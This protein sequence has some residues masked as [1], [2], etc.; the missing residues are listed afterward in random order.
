MELNW[1]AVILA[2][3]AGM[4]VAMAW[5]SKGPLADAWQRLTGILPEQSKQ[6]SR[7][8]LVQLVT[9]NALT[10]L[11][12]AVANGIA[13]AALGNDSVC[14]WLAL[15]VGLAAWLTLSASTMLQHTAFELKPPQL[16]L[17]NAAYQLAL[18]LSMA[19]VIGLV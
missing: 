6:A 3:V 1:L 8:N 4:A 18:F 7:R 2:L 9:A 5:Y 14:V 16:T 12:L 15:L 11:R 17:V 10:A 19:L 13:S